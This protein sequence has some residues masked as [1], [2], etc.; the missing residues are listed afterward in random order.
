MAI[1][2]PATLQVSKEWQLALPKM[3]QQPLRRVLEDL[4]HL[5]KFHSPPL[6][7][8]CYTAAPTLGRA[9]RFVIP[10]TPSTDGLEHTVEHRL[11]PSATSNCQIDVDY[12][13]SYAGGGTVWVNIYGVNPATTA[14]TLLTQVD[15]GKTI[16]AT[17]R[18]LR[19]TY[20][21]AAGNVTLHHLLVYPRPTAAPAVGIKTSGFIPFDDGLLTHADRAPVHTEWLN[22]LRKSAVALLRDR[23]QNCLSFVQEEA[24]A[25]TRVVI[26][27]TAFVA[28][29]RV[30]VYFPGQTS[31]SLTVEVKILATVSAGATASLVMVQQVPSFGTPDATKSA[32]FAADN[33]INSATLTLWLEGDGLGRFADLEISAKATAGNSTYLLAVMATWKPGD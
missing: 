18:A 14:A 29:P 2:A 33:A 15:T 16:P 4:N 10:I 1:T 22:R 12:T 24:T 3:A 5:W 21:P 6:A 30:R 13:T 11:L 9:V 17:A 8:V 31:K 25:N 28:F 32:T 23:R 7:S 19:V 26:T 27:A 20:T